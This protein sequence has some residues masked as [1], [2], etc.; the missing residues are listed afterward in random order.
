VEGTNI[1]T[2]A[3]EKGGIG[4]TTMTINLL[5]V[6]AEMG[7]RC[8]GI[9]LDFQG[10]L[11]NGLGVRN[12][13][14][15]T[16]KSVAHAIRLKQK[17]DAIR[18][19]AN[20]IGVD[21]LGATRELH[22]IATE[23]LTS[24]RRDNLIKF[25]LDSPAL[26][27]YDVVLID[28]RGDIN[29]LLIAALAASHYYLIP[30]FAEFD[31]ISGLTAILPNIEEIR[32]NLNPSL[33]FLGCVITNYDQSGTHKSFAEGLRGKVAR[34][35]NFR[36]FETMIPYSKTLKAAASSLKPVTQVGRNTAPIVVAYRALAKE[37]SPLLQGRKR[38]RVAVP[39]LVA[40]E[41][42]IE[43]L[44]GAVDLD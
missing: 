27:E 35:G 31:S 17:F 40:M 29:A 15:E 3:G 33:T 42:A 21:V 44:E 1:V 22:A 16:G 24:T 19:S 2:I 43:D 5:A 18:L 39:N 13:L 34:Q 11:T 4:K 25:M 14:N 8:L 26:A 20:I 37:L 32:T 28:T 12:Q 9:D 36:V 23:F 38:G 7:L 6:F 10:N 30:T 41:A